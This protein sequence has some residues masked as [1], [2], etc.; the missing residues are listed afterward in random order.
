MAVAFEGQ[1]AKARIKEHLDA[2]FAI[3]G[4][5]VTEENYS[6][7]GSTLVGLRKANRGVGEMAIIQCMIKAKYPGVDFPTA[8]A[9]AAVES[10]ATGCT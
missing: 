7:A 9:L 2:A 5:P 6:R 10:S 8:A 4:L 1:P 3:Y